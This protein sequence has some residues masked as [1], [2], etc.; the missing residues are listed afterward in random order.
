METLRMASKRIEVID[1]CKG[2]LMLCVI[3]V[4]TQLVCDTLHEELPFVCALPNIISPFY[5]CFFMPAFFLLSG[6]VSHFEK[7]LVPFLFSNLKSLLIPWIS[8][9]CLSAL[10]EYFIFGN[11]Q[12]QI[13]IGQEKYNLF[14]ECFWFVQALLLARLGYY[15]FKRFLSPSYIIIGGAC[16][17]CLLVGVYLN[18]CFFGQNSS[19]YLNW[20]HYRN[21]LCFIIFLWVG[22]MLKGIDLKSSLIS[23]FAILYLVCCGLVI[24][25]VAPPFVIY[26]DS[27][28]MTL[29]QIPWWLFVALTG[30][31]F[32][33]VIARWFAK[34]RILGFLGRNSLVVYLTHF[35]V[36]LC[37]VKILSAFFMPGGKISSVIFL[38]VSFVMTIVFCLLIASVMS[39]K[40][41]CYLLGK[42]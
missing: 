40:P 6:Y 23:I 39:R 25:H 1:V 11:K 42:F 14:V 29:S 34:S 27:V 36:Y 4:H 30:T 8:F 12:L 10:V 18:N 20:F 26:T 9:T 13:T 7:P 17:L 2:L 3:L 28:S 5:A 41:F 37:T 32:L 15:L 38:L 22:D 35:L 16:F 19:H 31:A 33:L 21:A 24:C